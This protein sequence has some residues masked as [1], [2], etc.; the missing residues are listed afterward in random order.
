MIEHSKGAF[1]VGEES[2]PGPHHRQG[3]KS[4]GYMSPQGHHQ[5][6]FYWPHHCKIY[7]IFLFSIPLTKPYSLNSLTI[8]TSF[9]PPVAL[10]RSSL[11]H[12]KALVC[13]INN[14]ISITAIL[15][16]YASSIFTARLVAA[17]H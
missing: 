11:K 7:R 12:D 17:L 3:H 4:Q 1:E 15:I 10:F 16:D 14:F 8:F 9:T 6:L 2:K 13:L 5:M